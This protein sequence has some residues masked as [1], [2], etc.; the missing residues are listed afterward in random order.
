MQLP[1]AN[2]HT[3]VENSP[4][5]VTLAMGAKYFSASAM[6]TYIKRQNA[7]IQIVNFEM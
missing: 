5:L 6:C 2:N 1:K 4:N 7:E 3:L